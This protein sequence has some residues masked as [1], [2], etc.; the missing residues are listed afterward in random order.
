MIKQFLIKPPILAS[1]GASDTLYLDLVVLEASISATLFKE[2]ENQK[3]RLILFVSKSLS[4]AKTQY[5][6]L[7][8]ATLALRVASK[9]LHPYFQVHPIVVLTNLPLRSTIHKPDLSGRKARCEIE[10][11]EFGIQ[12]K[13][14]LALKR[15]ILA[16]FFS[17]T[18]PTKYGPG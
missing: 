11:S 3:Q 15:Q 9:K 18:T 13:P 6:C 10:L 16:Y 1:P 8:Q 12:Y 7:E 4:E 17:T 5:T 14:H 2:D